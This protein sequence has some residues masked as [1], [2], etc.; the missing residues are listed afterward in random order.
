MNS[1]FDCHSLMIVF[2]FWASSHEDVNAI[3]LEDDITS[4]VRTTDGLSP[5]L[6]ECLSNWSNKR[7][8]GQN[9]GRVQAGVLRRFKASSTN[10]FQGYQHWQQNAEYAR[11]EVR[12]RKFSRVA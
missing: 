8:A 7:I 3:K 11:H 1:D 2:G 4:N 9:L 6:V 5:Y 12:K 10:Y